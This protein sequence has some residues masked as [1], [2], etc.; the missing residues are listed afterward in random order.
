MI[1]VAGASGELGRAICRKLIERG[2]TIY[3]MVRPS[4]APDAVAEL[5][6]MGVSL[7]RA[8]LANRDS[9]R[10]ACSGCDS[11]VSGM[12]AMG[13][14]GE[15][16][17]RVDRDGQLALVTAAAEEGVERFVYV[18]YS[19][20]IGKDDPLTLAKRAVERTLKH[21]GM[22]WTVLRPSF[23][24]ESWFS[25][26]LGFDVAAGKA[27]VYGTGLEPISWVARE[28]VAEF[29]AEAVDSEESRNM[30]LEIGG[31][32][33]LS[34]LEAIAVFESVTGRAIA[35]Q[36]V[37]EEALAARVAAAREPHE[38]CIAALMTAYAR[39]NEIPMHD[40]AERFGIELTSLRSWATATLESPRKAAFVPG[41]PAG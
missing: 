8:D 5:E 38:R 30:T 20:V 32:E 41:A 31:P 40:I 7:V 34:P 26:A 28:D 23:F 1:L 24:M 19:G 33:A 36:H 37:D 15:S 12:T 2:G 14:P 39:G 29:A 25:P 9:L 4:S 21:S 35:V 11:V 10:E 13:R 6:A 17:E 22:T 18:S 3:G 16:I 27:C